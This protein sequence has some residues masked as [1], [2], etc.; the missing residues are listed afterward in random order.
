MCQLGRTVTPMSIQDVKPA[1][2]QAVEAV[3]SDCFWQPFLFLL[4]SYTLLTRNFGQLGVSQ[5]Q[6]DWGSS[7]IS[8]G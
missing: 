4:S 5:S 2:G 1:R 7:A 6:E 3:A 8:W